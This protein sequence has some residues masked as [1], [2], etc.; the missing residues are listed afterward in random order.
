[1]KATKEVLD[2]SKVK[3]TVQVEQET[4]E[5]GMEKSYLKNR[6]DITVSGFRKGR[7]P[8][9]IIERFYGESIFFEDA[10]NEVFPETYEQAVAETGIEPVERPNFSIVQIGSGQ[11]LIYTAEVAVMPDLTLGQYKGIDAVMRTYTVA[12]DEVDSRIQQALERNARWIDVDDR[13]IKEGDRVIL[14]YAG[15]VDGIAFEGGTGEKQTLEIGS[16][17]FIP[18]F[19]QQ[20]IGMTIGEERDLEVKF[21]EDYHAE[22]LKGKDVVF[23]VILHDIK[24]KELPDL[25]DEFAKDVSEFDTLAEYREDLK[26]KMQESADE[27]AKSAVKMEVLNK[28]TENAAVEIP[29]VMVK[30]EVDGMLQEMDYQLRSNGMDLERYMVMMNTS[31]EDLRAHYHDEA[32]NRVKMQLVLEKIAQIEGIE[33][34]EEDMEKEYERLSEQYSREIG[35]IRRSFGANVEY[36]KSGIITQKTIAMLMSEAVLTEAPAEAVEVS[37][38]PEIS[39]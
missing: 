39:E 35:E 2:G 28:I 14:D 29:E 30:K 10:V 25:D 16:G 1:M 32:Y 5:K 15:T 11:G 12:D 7:V 26:Q 8:R 6:K 21:P 19:E 23:H 31:Q 24:E 18:G 38:T 36:I 3:L 33:A 27:Q 37:A 9:K 4:F 13:P 34:D 17:H 20:M 22:E